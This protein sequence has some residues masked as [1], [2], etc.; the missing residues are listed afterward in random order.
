MSESATD[1]ISPLTMKSVTGQGVVTRWDDA[2]SSGGI[3]HIEI[4]DWADALVIAPATANVV[5]KM[6]AGIADSPLLA[7]V[8]ATTAPVIVAPA[9][10]VNMLHHRATLDNVA[11]LR[12]RGISFVDPE[13]G[14]LACG[15]HGSGRLADPTV[16]FQ[17]VR[18]ALSRKDL[19]GKR[20]L[21]ATGPTREPI[22][23]VRF[24][25]NRS[26]GKMGIALA[27]EAFRRGAE[28]TVVHGPLQLPVPSF[29][30]AVPVGRAVEMRDAVMN[31]AFGPV[32]FD[33]VIMA[34]A[35]ADF[36][37]A[38]PLPKKMKKAGGA[39]AIALAPN[40]DILAELGARRSERPTMR[41]VGFAVETGE[42]SELIEELRRKLS[43]KKAD[44][45]VGNLAEEAFD[46][47]TNR[48]WLI[49]KNGRQDEV[50]TSLKERVANRV[51]DA[52]GRV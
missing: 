52:V 45:L 3:E 15:W 47:D 33:L 38:D 49:D 17:H 36:R 12:R 23:P 20:V 2:T 27:T 13:E 10:N 51:L 6:A 48:V 5:A 28:V 32:P 4:A 24:L 18:R 7:C 43:A 8:L 42:I 40:P 1:F 14:A 35:V 26:S 46:L 31:L 29:V 39:S 37:P 44:L 16:I 21:I 22:D 50:S 25:S 30:T 19:A 9:M 11:T 34:A 41:L